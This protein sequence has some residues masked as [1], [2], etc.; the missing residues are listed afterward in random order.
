MSIELNIESNNYS[1]MPPLPPV[2]VLKIIIPD[3]IYNEQEQSHKPQTP[4]ETFVKG[5]FLYIN[6]T[7]DR[8]MLVNAW[9]AIDELD[10]WDYMK[11]EQDNYMFNTD[12]ELFRIMA[13]IE[14]LGYNGHS[15]F[16]FAWTMRQLQYIAQNGEEKYRDVVIS[17]YE[18]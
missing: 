18:N 8:K 3:N 5:Q 4:R 6:D 16:T 15:G 13:K 17:N 10:L 9:N 7:H 14:E 12:R 1:A 2:Q 11:K